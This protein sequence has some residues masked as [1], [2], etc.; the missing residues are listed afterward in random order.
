[1]SDNVYLFSMRGILQEY[2]YIAHLHVNPLNSK[3]K[4]FPI[5]QNMHM[6]RKLHPFARKKG[7]KQ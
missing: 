5:N 2:L 1:M 7:K 3:L 6:V 4:L